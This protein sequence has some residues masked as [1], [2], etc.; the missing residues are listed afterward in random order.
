MIRALFF[1]SKTCDTIQI[2]DLYRYLVDYNS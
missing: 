1:L 2:I